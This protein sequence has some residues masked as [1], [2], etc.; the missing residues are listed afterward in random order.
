M[1][2]PTPPGRSVR[3]RLKLEIYYDLGWPV[4]RVEAIEPW[5]D[6]AIDRAFREFSRYSPQSEEWVSFP[7]TSN[8]NRYRVPDDYVTIRNVIYRPYSF[9]IFFY[10]M[11]PGWGA[12]YDW[13]RNYISLT[14]YT[15]TD[16]YLEMS[17][18]VTGQNGT[19]E[20]HHPYIY[21]YPMPRNSVPVF[22][23]V[24]K[25]I[26]EEAIREEEWIRRHA[27]ATIK[28]R[29][30]RVRSKYSSLP[31]PR[32]DITLDGSTLIQEGREDHEKLIEELRK[33]YEEPLGFFTDS[34]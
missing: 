24:Q 26:Q 22:V 16:M 2:N 19:W 8:V 4:V 21:L 25:L 7:T 11:F 1:P 30:G 3:D 28:I 27:L 13:L 20:F 6:N 31:G 32:G 18:R 12:W 15:I 29:L 10:D 17:E 5:I 9:G 14:D 34:S 23:K 33:E